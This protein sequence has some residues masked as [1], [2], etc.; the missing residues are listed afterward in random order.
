M[1]VIEN[2]CTE[3]GDVLLF[4]FQIPIIGLLSLS[5]FTDTIIGETATRYF[6]K[7]FRYSLDGINFEVWNSLTNSNLSSI[8]VTPT[9]YFY[10]K[11]RY[12]REGTDN[13]GD[14]SFEDITI[15]GVFSSFSC[16]ETFNN[17]IFAKYINCPDNE[18]L[19]WCL[20]V[21]KK[22]YYEGI[23]PNYILRRITSNLNEDK[24]YLDF[25]KSIACFFAMIV[26][27][28][29][30]ILENF[31][32][33]EEL[34]KL[35]LN[36][37]NLYF[38]NNTSLIDLNYLIDNFY[39]EIRQRGTNQ[40][41]KEK[42]STQLDL[43][44]IYHTKSTF[45]KSV[46]G[47]LLRLICYTNIDEFIFNLTKKEYVGWTINKSSPLFK[48]L[49][50]HLTINKA[51]EDNGD[52][53]NLDLYPLYNSQYI[54][55]ENDGNKQV[56]KILNIPSTLPIPASGIG[57]FNFPIINTNDL[58]KVIRVNENLDYQISFWV[59][60]PTF[61]DL[62]SD[63]TSDSW[64]GDYLDSKLTF[65][66][67]GLDKDDNFIDFINIANGN[68]SN[69]FFT[70]RQLIKGDTWFFVR[71]IIYNKNYSLLNINEARLNIGFGEN[72][73]FSPNIIKIIPIIALDNPL[74]DINCLYI[75]NLQI[76]PLNTPFSTGF[77]QIKN[78]IEIWLEKNNYSLTEEEI[79]EIMRRYLL[80][81]NCIF[82]NIWLEDNYDSSTST[83][84]SN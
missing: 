49:H 3:I 24:D 59:K 19:N 28:G 69:L 71:G 44:S 39:D 4:E 79:E 20:N 31:R 80:P 53:I 62:D 57:P 43:T 10:V 78:F 51:Y 65:G 54:S 42:S 12:T 22:L 33:Y 8:S 30:K 40:I 2:T 34:I 23:V 50:S 83:S 58:K 26:V 16:G 45:N 15:N 35:Y 18:A 11:Y 61:D 73:K 67:I 72:L 37:K 9:D 47:E 55:I 5:S 64:I 32:I 68:S 70:K 6:K 60:A 27:Y 7:E 56:L 81:Y 36:Q 25:W 66:V 82:K 74:S 29:R 76:K 1:A 48:G 17:S 38:C 13:T 46:N 84:T 75:W 63:S 52:I 14:L 77:I 41:Y 21:T